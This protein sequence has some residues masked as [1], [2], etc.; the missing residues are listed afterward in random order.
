MS[1]VRAEWREGLGRGRTYVRRLLRWGD[2]VRHV[3]GVTPSDTT[4]LL[5]ATARAPWSALRALGRWQD[6]S[7]DRDVEVVVRGVGRFHVRGRTDDLWH[8][9]PSREA[10]ISREVGRLRPGDVFVD[11][12]ANI[13]FYTV[14]A[15]HLV[16]RA[17][18]VIAIEMIPATS[19]I[20]RAHVELNDLSSV[21]VVEAALSDVAGQELV[22]SLPL[23]QHGQASIT[24]TGGR[25]VRVRTTTLASVLEGVDAVRLMKLDLEGAE[26]LALRG[27]GVA[28]EKVR[29]IVFEDWGAPE[30]GSFLREQGFVVRRLDRNNCIAERQ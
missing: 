7:L 20:L 19:A 3:R 30:V 12:G 17:G 5:S 18:Q 8:V 2:V 14:L 6:P 9:L 21:R 23:E 13:G 27:A 22:A 29:A 15:G 1:A 11:A 16:Q 26:L 10:A 25:E 24:R 28:L 4:A